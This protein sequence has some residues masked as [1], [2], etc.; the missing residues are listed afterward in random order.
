MSCVVNVRFK[1]LELR[2]LYCREDE[3]KTQTDFA[4]FLDHS[5][6]LP[7]MGGLLL[8]KWVANGDF[9]GLEIIIV[10]NSTK[11]T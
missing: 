7:S 6:T 2:Q 4:G 10:V 3:R 11:I 5:P 8:T 9:A 1:M